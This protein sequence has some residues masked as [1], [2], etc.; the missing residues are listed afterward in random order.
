M[1]FRAL[2]HFL[3]LINIFPPTIREFLEIANLSFY[4]MWYALLPQPI[5]IHR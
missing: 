4:V 1:E 2:K 5:G 3:S